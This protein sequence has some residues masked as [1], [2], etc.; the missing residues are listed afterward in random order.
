MNRKFLKILVIL[1]IATYLAP[2]VVLA[3]DYVPLVTLPGASEA[4]TPL[5]NTGDYIKGAFNL[6]IGI[7]A[8]LAIIMIVIGGIQYMGTESIGGKGA[9]LKRIKDAVLG[10]LLALGS[11]VILLTINPSLVNFNVNIEAITP[12]A[13]SLTPT[14]STPTEKLRNF[15]VPTTQEI[16]SYHSETSSLSTRIENEIIGD[17]ELKSELEHRLE[18]INEEISNLETLSENIQNR[19]LSAGSSEVDSILVQAEISKRA[20]ERSI[21]DN[22]EYINSKLGGG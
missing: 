2:N 3:L 14:A 10:L 21:N 9:G 15:T 11:Y 7:A 12:P 22:I 8:A 5:T 18:N 20:I 13:A 17:D 1:V 4:G 6:A 16:V 19:V